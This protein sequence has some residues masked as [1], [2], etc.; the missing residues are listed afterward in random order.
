MYLAFP[1]HP[2]LVFFFFDSRKPRQLSLTVDAEMFK[3]DVVFRQIK[4]RVIRFPIRVVIG[5][6]IRTFIFVL[7]TVQEQ[8]VC[9][10]NLFQTAYP[11]I[12][13]RPMLFLFALFFLADPL[14]LIVL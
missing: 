11:F 10:R 12:L 6:R 1:R 4:V 7:D 8:K 13:K 3:I 9:N 2:L 14:C 5:E